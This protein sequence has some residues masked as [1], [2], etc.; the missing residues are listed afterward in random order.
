MKLSRKLVPAIAM[1]LVSAVMLS[2]ASFAWFSMNTTV[3]ATGLNVQAKAMGSLII[4]A[5][6][7]AADD[8]V[9]GHPKATETQVAVAFADQ[10]QDLY[11]A[12]HDTTQFTTADGVTKNTAGSSGLKTLSAAE[13]AK[14]DALDGD[15]KDG[16]EAFS[17]VKVGDDGY[18]VADYY[19]DYTVYISSKSDVTAIATGKSLVATLSTAAGAGYA[20]AVAVDF[21]YGDGVAANS[22]LLGT[23]HATTTGNTCTILVGGDDV[24]IPKAD[25]TEDG[26]IAVTMRVYIDGAKSTVNNGNWGSGDVSFNVTFDIK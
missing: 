10:T 16:A 8:I 4:T 18:A 22:V 12:T 26:C 17:Y 2:T 9:T 13:R 5:K 3:N 23:A 19:I 21:Y 7:K 11:D 14:V 24:E 15:L 6:D 1:L 25:A 20:Q